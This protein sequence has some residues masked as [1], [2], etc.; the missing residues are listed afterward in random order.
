MA[1]GGGGCE[2]ECGGRMGIP[3]SGG[4]DTVLPCLSVN[5]SHVGSAPLA[6]VV[7]HFALMQGK[8]KRANFHTEC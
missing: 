8:P 5:C 2:R 3:V 4:Q 6:L 1:G 7:I